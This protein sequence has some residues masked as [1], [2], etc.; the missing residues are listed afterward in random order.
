[1]LFSFIFFLYFSFIEFLINYF[2]SIFYQMNYFILFV[3]VLPHHKLFF[4][5]IN[6]LFVSSPNKAGCFLVKTT[7]SRWSPLQPPHTAPPSFPSRPVLYKCHIFL[8]F[9]QKRACSFC[10][11]NKISVGIRNRIDF[12]LCGDR[13]VL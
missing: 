4:I 9:L 13:I 3:C 5:H 12:P 11:S 10:Y 6:T 8:R 1:M 2:R 7:K